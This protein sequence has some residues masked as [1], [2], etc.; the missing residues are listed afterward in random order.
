MY[1]FLFV[2][3]VFTHLIKRWNI[4]TTPT[5]KYIKTGH[6]SYHQLGTSTAISSLS[7]ELTSVVSPLLNYTNWTNPVVYTRSYTFKQLHYSATH[8]VVVTSA[9]R[10]GSSQSIEYI[11]FGLM[12]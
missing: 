8:K 10:Y 3:C 7:I 6:R 2:H 12:Y 11:A 1:V 9:N 4:S 5:F